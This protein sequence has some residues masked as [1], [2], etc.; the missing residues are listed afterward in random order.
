MDLEFSAL[1]NYMF[2]HSDIISFHCYE[3]KDDMEK[4][5][6]SLRQFNR[7]MMCTEYMARPFN[8]TFQDIMPVLKKYNVGAFNWGLVSGKTQTHCP[9]DSWEI[10]YEKEPD[11]WFHDIFYNNGTAYNQEEID[12][13]KDF[14]K[15]DNSKYRKVA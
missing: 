9:W 13:I 8:S 10:S 11:L 6:N 5:I 14:T 3:N 4:R 7:P 12:F 1:D 15:K 2:A